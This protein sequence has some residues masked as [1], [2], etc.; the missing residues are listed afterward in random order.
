M[1]LASGLGLPFTFLYF[2]ASGFVLLRSYYAGS[3]LVF[4]V[5][6]LIVPNNFLLIL[7]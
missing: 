6:L 7:L 4:P 3:G 1:I 5:Y 2:V